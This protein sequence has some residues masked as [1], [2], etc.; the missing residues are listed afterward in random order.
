MNVSD[1]LLAI[2]PVLRMH[3]AAGKDY[4]ATPEGDTIK[5]TTETA[6]FTGTFI[7]HLASVCDAEKIGWCI[8]AN[9]NKPY[10]IL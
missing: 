6:A 7:Q 2:Y 9:D 10:I 8:G 4:K 1:K 5:I 3:L